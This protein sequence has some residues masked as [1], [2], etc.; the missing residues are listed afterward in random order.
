MPA[1]L[2]MGL[3]DQHSREV[4]VP[5]WSNKH[6]PGWRLSTRLCLRPYLAQN[7][8]NVL[9]LSGRYAC[10]H[11]RTRASVITVEPRRCHKHIIPDLIQWGGR[12]GSVVQ[13]TCCSRG[14]SSSTSRRQLTACNSGS[15][16]PH[17]TH[18]IVKESECLLHAH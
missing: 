3:T 18:N 10:F 13:R 16:H 9:V 11:A 4:R 1:L 15:Y 8:H 5:A 6:F 2:T 14:P 7:E 17:P 12:G